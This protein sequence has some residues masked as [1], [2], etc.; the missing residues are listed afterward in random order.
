MQRRPKSATAGEGHKLGEAFT[1]WRAK[2]R[3]PIEVICVHVGRS[4]GTVYRWQSGETFP[5]IADVISLERR[6]RGLLDGY[7]RAA[8]VE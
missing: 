8:V 3:I 4:V 1:A 2:H 6:W 7:R 5:T